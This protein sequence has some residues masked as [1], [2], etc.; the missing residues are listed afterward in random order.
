MLGA[1]GLLKIADPDASVRAV[2]AYEL[3]P[4]SAERIIGYGLPFAEIALALLLLLGL[5]T[6]FAAATSGLL[7][8]AFIAAVGAAW[9]RGLSID[10]GCFGGGGQVAPDQT[11]YLEEILR[12]AGLLLLAGWLV[13]FPVSTYALDPE[14]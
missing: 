10:C 12:D 11:R 7:M 5:A 2:A 9:V 4:Y 14:R 3:L 13:M 8:I 6:R 1:A